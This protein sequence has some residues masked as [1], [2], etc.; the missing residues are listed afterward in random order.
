MRNQ[1]RRNM[2]LLLHILAL[3]AYSSS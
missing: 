3:R 1:N 2:M